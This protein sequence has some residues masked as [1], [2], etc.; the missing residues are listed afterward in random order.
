MQLIGSLTSPF[1]RRTRLLLNDVEHEFISLDIFSAEGHS[2]LGENNP[3]KK[4]PILKDEGHTIYDSR[5]IFNYLS[6]KLALEKLTWHQQNLLT[7]I[8]AANDSLVSLFLSMKSELPVNEDRLFF[9]L[10]HGRVD[11]VLVALNNAAVNGDFAGWA[12]PEICLFCLLDWITFREL[13]EWQ[14]LEGLVA[15][16]QTALQREEC[17]ATDPR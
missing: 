7:M 9:Q 1:A 14:H 16:Y 11:A 4:I 17:I 8:D 15:F 2:E 3:A 12:Y 5:I 6:E 13:V 10:Q